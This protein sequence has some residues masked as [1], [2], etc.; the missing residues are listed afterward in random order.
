MNPKVLVVCDS[1]KESLNADGVVEAIIQGIKQVDPYVICT[2]LPFSDGGE[3]ALDVL[4]KN[5][6]GEKVKGQTIDAFGRPISADY[7]MFDGGLVAWIELSQASGIHLIEPRLRDPKLTSTY[8]TGLLIKQ[9]IAQ[10]AQEIIL[11]I[12]GSATNDAGTGIIAAL[13]GQ[14]LDSNGDEL[15]V[16]GAALSLLTQIIL[17]QELKTI[18]WKVACD[19]IN[20]LIGP[21]GATYTYGPQKGA[22]QKDLETLENA[23]YNFSKVVKH[24]T[25]KSIEKTPGG[26]AAGGTA[27]G[28]YGLLNA[29]LVSGFELLG[30]MTNLEEKIKACDF[31]FTAEGRIDAQS[32]NGKVPIA[33]AEIAK[34][35]KK[36]IVGIAG[37]IQGPFDLHYSL[38][39]TSLFS[40]QNGPMDLN[41]SKAK[42]AELIKDTAARIW[43][44]IQHTLK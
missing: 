43:Q 16:G 18:K 12:G 31:I 13:G 10:G 33:V 6:L 9:A 38:G 21:E 34:K 35:F 29:E 30:T 7:F 14:F 28:L 44:L 23:L 37:S 4:D 39:L 22:S 36:P 20:P 26:G 1:F 25:G 17:P 42:S 15:P 3:G 5:A 11:G 2:P 8:G 41:E 27:A 24:T 19:V 32:V 40:I